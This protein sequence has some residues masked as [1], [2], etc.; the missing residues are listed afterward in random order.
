MKTSAKQTELERRVARKPRSRYFLNRVAAGL[1]VSPNTPL[2]VSTY[3]ET[4][5]RPKIGYLP[6]GGPQSPQEPRLWK[7]F[8]C[9]CR[10]ARICQRVATE[11]VL[12]KVTSA[13]G[14][15]GMVPACE[16]CA[17]RERGE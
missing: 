11:W 16:G 12:T 7:G 15:R 17:R 5:G 10:G 14:F 2:V 8:G 13:R 4:E 9:L 3:G 6:G 1:E